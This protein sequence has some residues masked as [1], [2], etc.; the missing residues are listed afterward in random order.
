MA[1]RKVRQYRNVTSDSSERPEL[2]IA[3]IFPLKTRELTPL[4]SEVL[5][6]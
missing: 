1:D 2:N 6:A 4:K 3:V 5:G